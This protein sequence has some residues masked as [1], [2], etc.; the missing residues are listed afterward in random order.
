M[1]QLSNPNIAYLEEKLLKNLDES[2][3][4]ETKKTSF[5]YQANFT[6]QQPH[7]QAASR[8]LSTAVNKKTG[9]QSATSVTDG[10]K[11]LPQFIRL[12]PTKPVS[13]TYRLHFE[14]KETG[15]V[16]IHATSEEEASKIWDN[17]DM[18]DLDIHDDGNLESEVYQINLRGE[19]K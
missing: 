12:E 19:S 16:D 8:A 15:Y 10:L 18:C 3:N 2:R 7:I 11:A 9:N 6:T 1:L 5:H 4:K 17:A 14:T 13:H